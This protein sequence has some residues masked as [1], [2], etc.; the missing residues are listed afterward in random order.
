[1][2]KGNLACPRQLGSEKILGLTGRRPELW[3]HCASKLWTNPL[4]QQSTDIYI[5]MSH[6][7]FKLMSKSFSPSSPIPLP[8]PSLV[9]IISI[10]GLGQDPGTHSFSPPSLC[11]LSYEILLQ[12][13]QIHLLPISSASVSAQALTIPSLG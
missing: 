10:N 9:V 6:K 5:W 13:F 7:H 1:M 11:P 12:I 8:P 2:Q 4:S 3:P